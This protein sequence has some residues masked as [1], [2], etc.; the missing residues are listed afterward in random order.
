M[1][2]GK[3]FHNNSQ[4]KFRLDDTLPGK[5]ITSENEAS[6]WVASIR[7]PSLHKGTLDEYR[8]IG[9]EFKNK[10]QLTDFYP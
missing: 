10:L 7:S 2:E 5:G 8:I 1:K 9:K 4:T 3:K 6:L